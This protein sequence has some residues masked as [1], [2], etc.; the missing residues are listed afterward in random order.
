M[1]RNILTAAILIVVTALPVCAQR[2]GVSAPRAGASVGVR[3]SGRVILRSGPAFGHNPGFGAFVNPRPYHPR[4][5]YNPYA[6]A[7]PYSYPYTIYPYTAYPYYGVGLQSDF[8]YSNAAV[9][10]YDAPAY[11]AEHDTGVQSDL[12]RLQAELNDVRQQQA[13]DRQQY[14]LN[15]PT[16]MP[17][18]I[19]ATRPRPEPPAPPT[20]LIFRDG[21]Q[22]EIHNYAVVGQVLWIFSEE[23]ARKVPLADLDLDATRQA[24]EARGVDFAVQAKP[25]SQ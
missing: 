12:Y 11:M 9:G 21:H 7:Y 8:V 13:A 4:R 17:R 10:T 2:R 14:A 19:P 22:A 15:T 6:Y 20:V 3:S 25:P 18:P 5:F 16:D 24:N 23:R 1:R